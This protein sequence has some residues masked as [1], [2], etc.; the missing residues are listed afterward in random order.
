MHLECTLRPVAP[1]GGLLAAPTGAAEDASL[2][3]FDDP[4][5]GAVA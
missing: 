4:D 2:A 5:V 1:E 3:V